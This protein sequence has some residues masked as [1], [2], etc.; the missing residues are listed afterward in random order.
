V[1]AGPR[2]LEIEPV[3]ARTFRTIITFLRNPKSPAL[4]DFP[5]REDHIREVTGAGHNIVTVRCE[6]VERMPIR[7]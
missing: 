5:N 1:I 4:A 7:R 3:A 2:S 6:A